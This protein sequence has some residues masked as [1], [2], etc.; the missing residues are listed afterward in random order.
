MIL[1]LLLFFVAVFLLLVFNEINE[2]KDTYIVPAIVATIVSI[3]PPMFYRSSYIPRKLTMTIHIVTFTVAAHCLSVV[4]A[5]IDYMVCKPKTSS[6]ETTLL[7]AAVVVIA[8]ASTAVAG[9]FMKRKEKK[10]ESYNE[11]VRA[12]I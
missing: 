1:G 9:H 10:E 6:R 7:Y 4:Y 2:C 12:D 5:E 11:L 8:Y 3:V